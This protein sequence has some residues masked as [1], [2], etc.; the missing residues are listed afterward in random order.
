MFIMTRIS[1]VFLTIALASFALV[2]QPPARVSLV[3]QFSSVTCLPCTPAATYLEDILDDAV[4][5][6]KHVYVKYPMGWPA[7]GDPYYSPS[8][9][10]RQIFYAVVWLPQTILDAQVYNTDDV[11]QADLDAKYAIPA[12]AEIS[13]TFGTGGQYVSVDINVEAFIDI[14]DTVRL[15]TAIFE[16]GS[17]YDNTITGI[18][19]HHIL[20]K[21]LPNPNGAKFSPILTGETRDYTFLYEF[22]GDY[23]KPDDASDVIDTLIEHTVEEFD[24]LGVAVWLQHPVTKEVYQ[25]TY[26]TFTGSFDELKENESESTMIL[27]PNPAQTEVKVILSNGVALTAPDYITVTDASGR[28]VYEYRPVNQEKM[29]GTLTVELN[30]LKSGIYLVHLHHGES[31]LTQRLCVTQ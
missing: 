28:Q 9:A 11:V 4:N 12:G 14:P 19:Y 7:P 5:T 6:D 30:R 22:K 17:W 25:A 29:A 21:M 23:V 2:A 20:K 18:E 1:T 8:S 16:K 15:Y 27:Y 13:A 26:A 10:G 24:D 31:V 3:E